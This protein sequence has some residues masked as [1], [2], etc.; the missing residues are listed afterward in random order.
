MYQN[1]MSASKKVRYEGVRKDK[2][3]NFIILSDGS[4]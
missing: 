3:T 1:S 2:N 4:P